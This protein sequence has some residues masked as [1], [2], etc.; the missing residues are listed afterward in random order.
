MSAEALDLNGLSPDIHRQLYEEVQREKGDLWAEVLVGKPYPEKTELISFE[1]ALEHTR[2]T[3]DL[4]VVFEDTF[5]SL[6]SESCIK[7][8]RKIKEHEKMH[9]LYEYQDGDPAFYLCLKCDPKNILEV[10]I[11]KN[12]DED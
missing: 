6:D 12:D 11:K 9:C 3:S 1:E 5:E 10:K 4:S 7:C 8:S 2:E